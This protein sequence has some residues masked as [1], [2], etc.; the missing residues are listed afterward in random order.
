MGVQQ[1][2]RACEDEKNALELALEALQLEKN[3]YAML[4]LSV[5][6]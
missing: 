2:L 1:S 5:A 4:G 3:K 6:L